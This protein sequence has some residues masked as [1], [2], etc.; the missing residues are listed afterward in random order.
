MI[1]DLEV[2]PMHL[3]TSPKNHN[4]QKTLDVCLLSPATTLTCLPYTFS[5]SVA[6]AVEKLMEKSN[7]LYNLD[8]HSGS[9]QYLSVT[10]L[11]KDDTF[12]AD[13]GKE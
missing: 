9:T 10:T 11:L 2:M 6:V 3:M 12:E 13:Y 8:P 4:H 7:R 1:T 5:M